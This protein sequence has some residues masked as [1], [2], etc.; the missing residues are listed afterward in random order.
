MFIRLRPYLILALVWAGYFHPLLLHP[1]RIL[2]TDHSDFTGQHL[3]AKLFLNREWREGGELPLWNP[4]HFCGNPFVHDIQVGVFYPPYTVTYLAPEASLGAAL[5]WVIAL[6]VLLAGATAFLY[7]RWR[8]LGEVGSLVTAVGFML[9]PKWMAHCILAGQTITVGLA[10]LPLVLLGLEAAARDRRVWPAVGAGLAFTLLF[11]GTHPQWTLY[12]AVFAAVWTLGPAVGRVRE[13][14]GPPVAGRAARELGWWL[15]AG[16]LVGVVT[17]SLAAVQLLP[18]LEASGESAR[19]AV[20]ASKAQFLEGVGTLFRTV[21]PSLV[22]DVPATWEPRGLLGVFWLTAA[23]AAPAVLGRRAWWP[24]GILLGFLAF[25]VGGSVLFQA[26]PGF[27]FFRLPMRC[28]VVAAFPLAFLAGT[29]TDSLARHGWPEAT[30]RGLRRG[31]LIV[32]FAA[33]LPN[34]L[35]TGWQYRVERPWP[36]WTPFLVYWGAVAAS[37]PVFLWLVASEGGPRD[38]RLAA[39]LLILAAELV[40]PLPPVE[41]RPQAAVYPDSPALE[42]V[43]QRTRPGESRAL[44]WAV[45]EGFPRPISVFGIGNPL[46]LVYRIEVLNGYNPLDVRN[47][48]EFAWVMVGGERIEGSGPVFVLQSMPH[49][50]SEHPNM[51]NSLGARFLVCRVGE[52]AAMQTARW[53]PVGADPAPPPFP[54]GEAGAPERLPPHGVYENPAAFPRVWLVPRAATMPAGREFEALRQTDF[55]RVVLLTTTDPLPPPAPAGG[56]AEVTDYRPNRVTVRVTGAVGGFLVLA[57][58][59][60]PGWVCRVGGRE[61]PVYRANHAFRAV[62]VP[63]GDSE[64]VFSFEPR[65]YSVGRQ[66]SLAA[67]GVLLMLG[68]LRLGSGFLRRRGR[69]PA[70]AG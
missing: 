13:P 31:F 48:R 19:G 49:L 41:V 18:T 16:L 21:G 67:G 56:N 38:L 32:A 17:A 57:D 15:G 30:R 54:A 28:L 3:P 27:R 43:R 14:A 10:W 1:G 9:S 61:V 44:D 7:A 46:A 26:V 24:L 23:L 42:M 66:V 59:W 63:P 60:F 33:V 6:H 25:A 37:V 12:A 50:E 22:L 40:T 4:Y 47:Y 64:V 68:L 52:Q 34:F 39:W 29:V 36:V 51:F 53:R 70:P 11:L 55:G 45:V 65:S 5:S 35:C 20:P 2:Y 8:G 69:A 58:V 62:A